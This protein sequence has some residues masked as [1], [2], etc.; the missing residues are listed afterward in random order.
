MLAD[1][2]VGQ[3][4]SALSPAVYRDVKPENVLLDRCGHVKLA[5]FGSAARLGP[6]GLVSAGMPVGTPDYLAPEVLQ[7]IN[8]GPATPRKNTPKYGV[9]VMAVSSAPCRF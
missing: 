5:D 8:Q 3:L 2:P 6:S 1:V 7:T 9:S 4:T